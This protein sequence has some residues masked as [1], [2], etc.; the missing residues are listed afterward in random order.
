MGQLSDFIG[1]GSQ[2]ADPAG[3]FFHIIKDDGVGGYDSLTI[4]YEDFISEVA[5]DITVLEGLVGIKR[6]DVLKS[7]DFEFELPEKCK[8]I[9]MTLEQ[10]DGTV[11]IKAG[12]TLGGS[13]LFEM[14]EG[15]TAG[16]EDF[17]INKSFP[18]ATT[19]YI[20]RISGTFNL[21]TYYIPEWL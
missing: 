15:F 11:D 1:T 14:F 18:N 5:A 13:E 16:A 21:T 12:T 6:V 3:G 7:A 2:I 9:S 4:S 17:N 19:V 10:T 8:L 20:T